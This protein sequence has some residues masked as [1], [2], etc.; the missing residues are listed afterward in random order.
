MEFVYAALFSIGIIIVGFGWRR[1]FIHVAKFAE[2]IAFAFNGAVIAKQST[3]FT[4][5]AAQIL[6]VNQLVIASKRDDGVDFRVVCIFR[7]A[8]EKMFM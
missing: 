6:I 3:E 5:G 7:N 4:T 2:F 1:H 8:L